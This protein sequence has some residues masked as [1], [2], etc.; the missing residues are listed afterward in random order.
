MAYILIWTNVYVQQLQ[1][2]K[3]N[4]AEQVVSFHKREG[5]KG[6]HHKRFCHQ[7]ASLVNVI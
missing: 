3:T 5:V 2:R 1:Q 4:G 7:V 6:L